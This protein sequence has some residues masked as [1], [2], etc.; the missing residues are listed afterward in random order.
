M[1][2]VLVPTL[3]LVEVKWMLQDYLDAYKSKDFQ[4]ALRRALKAANGDM[5]EEVRNRQEVCMPI[6]K[7]I[8]E[9]YGFEPTK[10]GVQ[11]SLRATTSV[12]NQYTDEMSRL[13]FQLQ[14]IINPQAQEADPNFV[15]DFQMPRPEELDSR[16]TYG[17]GVPDPG[18][19][20][21][22]YL[23]VGGSAA[24]G[25]LV[26][27]AAALDSQI[28]RYRLRTGAKIEA[29]EAPVDGRLHYK[30]LTGEGPDFGWVSMS[31]KGQE[32]VMPL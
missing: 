9:K 4:I 32:L 23:V 16:Y 17:L 31:L 10:Q 20:G 12:G 24:G 11:D 26:R 18:T 15:P 3:S 22:V 29:L 19:R 8:L 27:R 21:S 28:Y 1:A 6:Q 25:L 13:H 2:L 30:R 7:P 14:W 5:V